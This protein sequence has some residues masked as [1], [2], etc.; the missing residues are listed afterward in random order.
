RLSDPFFEGTVRRQLERPF[1]ALFRRVTPIEAL[2]AFRE[3]APPAGFIY[4]W[5]RCGSTLVTQMLAALPENAAV[6]EA[7]PVE[8]V[9]SIPGAA[10][11]WL[12]PLIAAMGRGARTFVKLEAPHTLALPVLQR[13][14]PE[15]PWIFLYRDPV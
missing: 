8:Q 9:L 13:I 3:E 1:R 2:D 6:S 15:T 7:A 4:H 11:R 14:F 12:R 5:S 10:E